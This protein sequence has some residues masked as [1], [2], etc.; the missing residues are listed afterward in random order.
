MISS[1]REEHKIQG[2]GPALAR[3]LFTSS[4]EMLGTMLEGATPQNAMDAVA[5]VEIETYLPD[6]LLVKA[7]IAT[8][9][10]ALEAR[11]PFLDHEFADWAASIPA[12]RRVFSRN[13]ALESKGLLKK[14]MEND[15]D[16]TVLYRRKQGFSVPVAHWIG[17]EIRDFIVDTLTSH[18]FR[19]RE[20]INP[21]FVQFMLDRHFSN[22]E[23][24]G[25]RLWSLLC[26]EL[27]YQTFIDQ[28]RNEPLGVNVTAHSAAQL[29]MA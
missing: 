18:R 25:T 10:N 1:F 6:D 7:D 12:E 19:E 26:L 15:L 29:E 17:N 13:G 22:Y 21:K 24:H 4:H 9:A 28:G 11:S 20:L 16:S 23:D 3:F 8:M 27:W 5:R 2:Y 14:A